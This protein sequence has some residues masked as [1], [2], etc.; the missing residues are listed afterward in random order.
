M[1]D[2]VLMEVGEGSD[3]SGWCSRA[4]SFGRNLGRKLRTGYTV[5]AVHCS[6]LKTHYYCSSYAQ[7]HYSEDRLRNMIHATTHHGFPFHASR[8][9]VLTSVNS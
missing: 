8:K 2:C 1:F 7:S 3:K 9:K 5:K 4:V 6:L